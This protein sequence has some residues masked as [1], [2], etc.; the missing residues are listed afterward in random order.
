MSTTT[1]RHLV[2]YLQAAPSSQHRA[3][4]YTILLMPFQMMKK[5]LFCCILRKPVRSVTTYWFAKCSCC[6]PFSSSAQIPPPAPKIQV[7]LS[8]V[9]WCI[10]GIHIP[11]L[12]MLDSFNAHGAPGAPGMIGDLHLCS[13][14]TREGGMT[15]CL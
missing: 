4:P 15:K 14:N 6:F 9:L 13:E 2:D 5:R 11:C 10:H 7:H 3:L 1:S 12:A 8:L